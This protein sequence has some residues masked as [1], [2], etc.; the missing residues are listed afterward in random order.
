MRAL[1]LSKKVTA[2]KSIASL[3]SSG[4]K[5]LP[6]SAKMSDGADV[7]EE[8]MKYDKYLSLIR[9]NEFNIHEFNRECKRS[10]T[11]TLIATK[12]LYDAE[13]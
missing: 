9:T 5:Q 3:D 8:M 11:L 1:T 6:S 12:I 4:L 7:E 13:L 10:K 2:L